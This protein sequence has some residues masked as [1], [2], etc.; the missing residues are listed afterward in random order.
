MY[1]KTLYYV[2]YIQYKWSDLQSSM[3]VVEEGKLQFFDIV[4]YFQHQT[5]DEN[6]RELFYLLVLN[7]RNQWIPMLVIFPS[8][9]AGGM[10]VKS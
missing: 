3:S 7:C 4:L 10:C 5:P 6:Y 2:S 8:P 9:F 1:E